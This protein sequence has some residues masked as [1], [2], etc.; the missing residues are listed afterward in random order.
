MC[1]LKADIPQWME[2]MERGE[3]GTPTFRSQVEQ[4]CGWSA[5]RKS[6]RGCYHDKTGQYFKEKIGTSNATKKPNK[7][8]SNILIE[9]GRII[10]K[11]IDELTRNWTIEIL[12][13]N[14]LKKFDSEEQ[15]T[16]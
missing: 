8:N 13:V 11:Y 7:T 5:R 14:V 1:I 15:E 10:L 16:I 9:R 12:Y 4:K 3:G 2:V 6:K